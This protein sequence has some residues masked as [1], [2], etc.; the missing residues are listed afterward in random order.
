LPGGGS[1][2]FSPFCAVL[3]GPH[4]PGS[5]VDPHGQIPFSAGEENG[6]RIA[7]AHGREADPVVIEAD[8]VRRYR[9]SVRPYPGMGMETRARFEVIGAEMLFSGI[10]AVVPVFI[11][12]TEPASFSRRE[13]DPPDN[14][15]FNGAVPDTVQGGGEFILLRVEISSGKVSAHVRNSQCSQNGNNGEDCQQFG[16]GYALQACQA[17]KIMRSDLPKSLKIAFAMHMPQ[18]ISPSAPRQE[19]LS[20]AVLYSIS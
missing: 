20:L 6:S 12:K 4:G 15:L 8:A 18:N 13:D 2:Q 10:Q 7:C 1:S 16:Q 3:E 19:Y 11:S 17:L 5:G 9:R 14:A